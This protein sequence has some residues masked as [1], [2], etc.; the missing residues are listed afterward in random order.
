MRSFDLS[1][2]QDESRVPPCVPLP[3]CWPVHPVMKRLLRDIVTFLIVC[4]VAPFGRGGLL[5][6]PPEP[7]VAAANPAAMEFFEKEV[8]P[9][10]IN[11]C[12]ECHS[13][14]SKV[15]GGLRLDTRQGVLEGGDS[16]PAVVPGQPKESL[17]VEALHFAS[18]EMP[19]SGKLASDEIAVFEKW[20]EMGAPDPRVDD[21]APTTASHS[22]LDKEEVDWQAAREF[23]A[24]QSPKATPPPIVSRPD[25]VRTPIDAFVLHRLETEGLTPNEMADPR[26]LIRRITFDLTGLP[27]TRN[28][29][30]TFAQNPTDEAFEQVVNDLLDRPQYGERWAQLWLDIARYAEDQAHIVGNNKS[31]F[32]PNAYR[33]RDWV[34]DAFNR[35]LPYDE[36]VR[37][38][39]AAD[40][41]APEE[42]DSHV[43]LGFIGLGPKY[44]RR[45]SPEVMAEEWEDRVDLVSR[46]LLGLT[47]ACA[48]C[49]DHKYDPIQTE[50][51][52]AIAG[53]FASTTMFNQP[54]SEEV[55]T[56]KNGE[57][58]DPANAVH[59]VREAKPQDLAVMIRG[60]V[61]N[62][63]P[64][65]ERRFLQVL[66][67]EDAQ[68]F[69]QGSG[70]LELAEAIT[71]ERNPLTARVIVNRVWAE[72][73]GRPLVSTP[74][75]FG[76]L[77]GRPTHPELLDDLAVRFM[78]NG[79]SLKW[80]HREIVLSS[81]YRQ[82][83]HCAPEKRQRDP[84]NQFYA[85]QSRRRLSAEAWRDSILAVTGRLTPV[86]GGPSMEPDDP[87]AVR[88]TVYSN[89]SRFQLNPMLALF[90]VPDPNAHAPRRVETTTPLQKLFVL[91]SPFM[92]TAAEALVDR[93]EREFGEDVERR[94]EGAY[95]VLLAREPNPEELVLGRE[96]IR[97]A[98][99]AGMAKPWRDYAQVLL[100]SNEMLIID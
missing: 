99:Q 31:L 9:L 86:V 33:Y 37:L 17:M 69:T 6:A 15:R 64:V 60:D 76:E 24:Y 59:I 54:L 77:G 3:A 32:Y 91:N 98:E 41:I 11:R 29:V 63:G 8:R 14:E 10:L 80:L 53:V 50:D 89:R 47:V 74:S 16:G 97:E 62:R 85:R 28:A 13:A 83:S 19:P 94:I 78:E 79:W 22:S 51:Y 30:E 82:A 25:W 18:F 56:N 46:G 72:Y 4:A 5:A 34:I 1:P 92:V 88:R 39:L 40:L 23:W 68:P 44:Y 12:Y 58:K 70:R 45:N 84:E 95:H 7:A 93:L 42:T 61:K 81:T 65:V 26:T 100:A 90:D 73:F 43:A 36:F 66:A 49:H 57:A 20:I 21:P 35:D 48:R 71:D 87:A 67:N 55:E 38:Q 96:F 52:Y 27:P 75:N 2:L